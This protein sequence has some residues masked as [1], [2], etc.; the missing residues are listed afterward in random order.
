MGA[1]LARAGRRG[2]SRSPAAGATVRGVS[3]GP[4]RTIVHATGPAAAA[5]DRFRREGE[6]LMH[7]RARRLFLAALTAAATASIGVGPPAIAAT[8]V[9]AAPHAALV[10][11]PASIVNTMVFANGG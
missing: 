7:S 3:R 8:S 6:N 4:P 10:S 1:V 11:D 5:A 9:R 2:D